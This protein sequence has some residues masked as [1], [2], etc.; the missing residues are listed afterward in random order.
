MQSNSRSQSKWEKESDTSKQSK[1][2]CCTSQMRYLN[3]HKYLLKSLIQLSIAFYELNS[4]IRG[5]HGIC[6]SHGSGVCARVCWNNTVQRCNHWLRI[7]MLC[8]VASRMVSYLQ[9][10]ELLRSSH[11]RAQTIFV[12]HQE[13]HE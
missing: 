11:S 2:G 4:S 12:R 6:D 3:S 9:W 5:N 7:V 13:A 1:I 10:P 8:F